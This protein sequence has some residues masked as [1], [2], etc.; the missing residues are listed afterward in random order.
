MNTAIMPS[1]RGVGRVWWPGFVAFVLVD[2]SFLLISNSWWGGW[3][4]AV[5]RANGGL[6]IAV[7]ILSGTVAYRAL[8]WNLNG[9]QRLLGFPK[10]ASTVVRFV[11]AC[12]GNGIFVGVLGHALVLTSALIVAWLGKPTDILTVGSLFYSLVP[13]VMASAVGTLVVV[14]L[15]KR[16]SPAVAVAACLGLAY[17]SIASRLD[18]LFQ[19]GAHYD[20]V[21]WEY[22][23]VAAGYYASGAAAVALSMLFAAAFLL[24]RKLWSVTAVLST[25]SVICVLICGT[26]SPSRLVPIDSL[27]TQICDE[28]RPTLCIAAGHTRIADVQFSRIRA[29]SEVLLDAGAE[30]P[31]K[32]VDPG[33]STG[34]THGSGWLVL[35]FDVS[36]T[37]LSAAD[38]AAAVSDPGACPQLHSGAG[39][40]GTAIAYAR[41]SLERW[42]V[43]TLDSD[44]DES[45][46]SADQ[47]ADFAR[48]V[49]DVYAALR[50]CKIPT[51]M[52]NYMRDF[53]S[54]ASNW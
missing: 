8:P 35:P 12:F 51:D 16:W 40:D 50:A 9:G 44:V 33:W 39:G 1:L 27:P 49:P 29:S 17:L 26:L 47:I 45:T 13:I 22:S 53:D 25:I 41:Y 54:A 21:G 3:G 23:T 42:M 4:T 52:M 19:V 24:W 37:P 48:H 32:F 14:V 20:L 43:A 46:M 2:A 36:V 15:P 28:G 31:D 7:P 18:G 34:G 11:A 10:S 30:L 6:F 5:E 38:A